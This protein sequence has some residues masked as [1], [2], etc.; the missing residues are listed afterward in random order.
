MSYLYAITGDLQRAFFFLQC[1]VP[2]LQIRVKRSFLSEEVKQIK[3]WCADYSHQTKMIINDDIEVAL[4]VD[5]WGVHLGQEDVRRY[6]N[7]LLKSLPIRVGISTHNADEIQQSLPYKPTY[8]GF[9]PVFPTTTKTLQYPPLGMQQVQQIVVQSTLPMV[10]IGGINTEKAYTLAKEVS[11]HALA[12]ISGLEEY[13]T[14]QS[15]KNFCN[16]LETG[17]MVQ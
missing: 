13:Q 3:Q 6:S 5:A 17:S 15:V 8:L 10:L 4:A 11:P 14:T 9:G 2:Y 1:K 7:T 12:M 16:Q